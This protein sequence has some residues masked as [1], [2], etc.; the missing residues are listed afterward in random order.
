MSVNIIQ[1]LQLLL[2]RPWSVG[3]RGQ[4]VDQ[5]VRQVM[6]RA[7]GAGSR[8]DSLASQAGA[9]GRASPARRRLR[10]SVPLTA[11]PSVRGPLT[12]TVFET[13]GK[14]KKGEKIVQTNVIFLVRTPPNVSQL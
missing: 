11:P 13:P 9:Y 7:T 1:I 6:A 14:G 12:V 10:P 8:R 5:A 4:V 3:H 2:S